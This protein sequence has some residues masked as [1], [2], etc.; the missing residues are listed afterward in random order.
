MQKIIIITGA[1]ATG[2]STFSALLSDKLLVPSI[3]KDNIKE[4]LSDNFGFSSREE[5]LKLSHATYEIM[6][7]FMQRLMMESKDFILEIKKNLLKYYN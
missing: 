2:K 6:K 1:L 5:N 4:I 3:N 7:Y